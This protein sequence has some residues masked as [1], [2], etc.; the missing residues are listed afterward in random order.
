MDDKVVGSHCLRTMLG[1]CLWLNLVC[2]GE[3][4]STHSDGARTLDQGVHC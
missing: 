2:E 1:G 4:V 3:V